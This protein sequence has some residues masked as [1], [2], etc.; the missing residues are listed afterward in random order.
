[1]IRRINFFGGPGCGKSTLAAKVF[2][3]LSSRNYKVA[4]VT[5]WIKKWAILGIKPESHDQLFVFANQLHEEDTLLRKAD[6]I[7]TDSPVLLNACYSSFY[8]YQGVDHLV[9]LSKIFD[10][11]F[12]A[13]N[14]YIDRTVA[15]EQFGR[16]QDYEQ[17]LEFDDFLLKFVHRNANKD[18]VRFMKVDEF[19]LIIATIMAWV[20]HTQDKE[21]TNGKTS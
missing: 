12:P 9:A 16:Y 2:A 10:E 20:K 5:E 6:F 17:A 18:S 8:G 14:I 13:L 3:E 15:Y 19:D 11:Q 21:S 4:H 1:M 7:V